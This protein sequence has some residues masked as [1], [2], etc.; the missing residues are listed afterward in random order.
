MKVSAHHYQASILS[1]SEQSTEAEEIELKKLDNTNP[2]TKSILSIKS[3]DDLNRTNRSDRSVTPTRLRYIKNTKKSIS[4][5]SVFEPLVPSNILNDTKT[6]TNAQL[7]TNT[8]ATVK[9]NKNAIIKP[10]SLC[11]NCNSENVNVNKNKKSKYFDTDIFLKFFF[12]M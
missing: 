8:N 12:V 7:N 1:F 9:K 11:P 4:N 6:T 3:S 10:N 5:D 2:V